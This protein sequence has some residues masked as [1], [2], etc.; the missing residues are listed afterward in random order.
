MPVVAATPAI[1]LLQGGVGFATYRLVEGEDGRP[2][3]FINGVFRLGV[4]VDACL[5]EPSLRE[6]FRFSLYDPMD[7][8]VYA[9]DPSGG[10]EPWGGVFETGLRIADGVWRLNVAPAAARSTSLED[11]VVGSMVVAGLILAAFLALLLR[12]LIGRHRAL[13]ESEAKYRLLV[14]NQTDMVVKVESEG[15]VPVREPFVLSVL[16]QG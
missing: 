15:R 5:P 12:A 2:I 4:L 14:E 3:G 13:R 1:D 9:H 16:R 6:G 8:L 10:P 11:R 7:R